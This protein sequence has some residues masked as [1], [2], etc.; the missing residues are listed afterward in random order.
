[1]RRVSAQVGDALL[2]REATAE[3]FA[4]AYERWARV[5]VMESPEGWVYRVAVNVCRRNW[6]HA[7]LE[8]RALARVTPVVVRGTA[9]HHDD[10]Y[11]ALRRLPQRQRTALRLRYWDDL[12]EREVADSMQ[13][14]S[15][16]VS[17][18]LSTARTRLRRVLGTDPAGVGG[19]R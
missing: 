12:T 3:A 17:A 5:A 9:D 8:S 18:L 2:G 13:I 10:V 14:A 19:D 16:T 4:R 7:A 6:R 1:M 15:G 11:K